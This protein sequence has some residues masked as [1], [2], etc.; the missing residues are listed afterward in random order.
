MLKEISDIKIGILLPKSSLYPTIAMDIR[1]GIKGR[2]SMEDN[3]NYKFF[4]ESIGFGGDDTVIY[5]KAE[6]L[7]FQ[8]EVLIV[9]A[10]LDHTAALKLESLFTSMKRL[11]IVL[12]PGGQTPLTWEDASPFR[13]TISLQAALNSHITGSFAGKNGANNTFFSTS[14]YEG[15]YL[16]CNSYQNGFKLAGGNIVHHSII[17]LKIKEFNEYQFHEAI[18]KFQPDTVLAQFSAEA[19]AFFLEKY[20]ASGLFETSRLYLSPFMMEES[21]MNTV[22]FPFEGMEG[23]VSWCSKID[24]SDNRFFAD[25]IK[26]SFNKEANVFSL[27]GWEAALLIIRLLGNDNAPNENIAQLIKDFKPLE[28]KAPRGIL[29]LHTSSHVFFG[30]AYWVEVIKNEVSG[31]CDLNIKE[32]LKYDLTHFINEIPEGFFSKWTNT[33]LCI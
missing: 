14:F 29:Q 12:D 5:D 32:T 3:A 28:I 7:L 17:P 4:F 21:W 10:F 27:L 23:A 1:D 25:T 2:L 22:P 11:L 6:K 31:N 13:Y 18:T 8:E 33:Y 19:G 24:T 15:G 16:Q 9:V 20:K 26:S 30:P